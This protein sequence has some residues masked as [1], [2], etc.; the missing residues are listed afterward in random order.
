MLR[1][2]GRERQEGSGRTNP[3]SKRLRSRV[4]LATV[5]W[6]TDDLLQSA[7][8]TVKVGSE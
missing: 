1:R 2:Q 6:G 4:C 3:A 7:H 8:P 5:S